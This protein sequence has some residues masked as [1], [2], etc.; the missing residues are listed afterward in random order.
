MYNITEGDQIFANMLKEKIGE[1]KNTFA[2]NLEAQE[3]TL[4]LISKAV[5][6]SK[7]NNYKNNHLIW[8]V[9]CYINMASYDLKIIGISLIDSKREWN[10]RY[11]ARQAALLIYESSQDLFK[12]FGKEF[13][14]T[15]SM[16]SDYESLNVEMIS[17]TKLLN[18][19]N[20]KHQKRLHEIRNVATAHRDKDSIKQLNVIQSISWIEAFNYIADFDNI[21]NTSGAFL[22]KIMNKSATDFNELNE[23]TERI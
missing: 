9:A 4:E 14:S 11:F 8:N 7:F 3:S 2:K 6:D 21:L 5:Q 23:D 17:I 10:K 13:R 22:Q 16:L 19:Y 20:K 15:I 18:E 12:L 1:L